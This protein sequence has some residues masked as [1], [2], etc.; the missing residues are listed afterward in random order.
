MCG[1]CNGIFFKY[2]ANNRIGYAIQSDFGSYLW[3]HRMKRI[4]Q[5]NVSVHRDDSSAIIEQY[6]IFQN[7]LNRAGDCTQ[8]EREQ[9]LFDS[10]QE[11]YN[12]AIK[13]D[14]L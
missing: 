10:V 8:R 1:E 13:Q 3:N 4:H 11:I 7:M 12:F 9:D 2:R 5:N 14:V 6:Q